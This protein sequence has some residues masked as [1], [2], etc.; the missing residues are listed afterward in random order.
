MNFSP[1]KYSIKDEPMNPFI[2]EEEILDYLKNSVSTKKKVRNIINKSLNN[3]RLN[4]EDVA[5]LINT[6][7]P[8]L[9][10]EIKNNAR[11][12]KQRIYGNRIVLF[13]PLYIG[14]KCQN[15]CKY[16]GF[17]VSNKEAVRKTLSTDELIDNVKVLEDAGHK[18]VIAVFGEHPDYSPEF[19]A[20]CVRKIYKVKKDRGE[21]RRVNIN[22]APFD[23]EGF[24]T[25][26]DAGIGT[27]QIFQETY[28]KEVYK[29]YHP[30]G[31]KSNYIFRLTALD[32]AMEAGIDDVGLGVLF[33]LADWKFDLLALIRHVNHLEACYNVGPHT[34]S[35]PRIQKAEGAEI[36][37]DEFVSDEDFS[38]LVAILRLAVPYTGLILT[39]R[40]SEQVRDEVLEFG[41]SQIDAGSNIEI[42]GYSNDKVIK[43]CFN[44][45]LK[46]EQFSLS[47]TRSLNEVVKELIS[48]KYMPSFCTACYRAGRTGEHF[49]EYSVPGFINRFCTPN[50]ILTL[51]EF[52]EDYADVETRKMGNELI[53]ESI[54]ELENKKTNTDKLHENLDL[55]RNGKRD[56]FF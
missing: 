41:C 32:R 48:D 2:N 30:S 43:T 13:A 26:K 10:D 44:Q 12:L 9:I 38:K 34:I 55:I 54:S 16:C 40:E 46:K 24:K 50:S 52:L 20:D 28:H 53:Q 37:P 7:Q 6:D 39:A 47:D 22:A 1:Q 23:I 49:M 42:N 56:L 5:C 36:L 19:I 14:N 27:Y 31:H 33:G 4:I 3:T 29:K 17:R 11:I 45:D 35:F 21:I 18:R 15:D 25:I 51:A 8:E